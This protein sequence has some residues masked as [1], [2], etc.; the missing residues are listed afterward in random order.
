MTV[1][2]FACGR[3]GHWRRECPYR[4]GAKRLSPGQNGA[5]GAPPVKPTG[6]LQTCWACGEP[7]HLK[8]ECPRGTRRGNL[9]V[10]GV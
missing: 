4:A 7:G 10:G 3:L 1:Y 2:C 6:G 8:S 9:E 5:A